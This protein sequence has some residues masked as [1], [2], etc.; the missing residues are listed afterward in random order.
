[1]GGGG[2]HRKGCQIGEE[3]TFYLYIIYTLCNYLAIQIE[4]QAEKNRKFLLRISRASAFV[5]SQI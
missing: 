2:V 5:F 3:Q 4:R 1:M